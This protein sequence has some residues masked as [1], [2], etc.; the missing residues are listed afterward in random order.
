MRWTA[1]EVALLRELWA[2]PDKPPV[3]SVK[4]GRSENAIFGKADR[5]DLP[6]RSPRCPRRHDR[7]V[8][9][10]DVETPRPHPLPPGARTL[11]LM[12]SERP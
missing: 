7:W 6:C 2:G 8:R 10:A 3:I 11:P 4:L 12:A 5:L 9:P 1:E